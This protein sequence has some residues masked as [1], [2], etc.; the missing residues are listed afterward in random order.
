MKSL[1]QALRLLTL[2]P[3]PGRQF[4]ASGSLESGGTAAAYPLAGLVIGILSAAA[5]WCA[6]MILGVW[7]IA[8]MATVARI[9]ITGGMHLDGLADLADGWGGGR[10]RDKR[11]AIMAD[12]RLGSF[13]ALALMVVLCL[14]TVFI[15]EWINSAILSQNSEV[16]TFLP[17]VLIPALSR[18]MIPLLM[19]GFPA[20]RPGGMGKQAR[21][22]VTFIGAG[23]ALLF[24]VL[25]VSACFFPSG[26]I[27]SVS[28][29]MI[30]S[31]A[32]LGISK[33][34]GGLTGD[35][36]GALIEIG[37]TAGFLGVLIFLR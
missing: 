18:G 27:L 34:L 2:L 36:Y 1:I 5:A 4:G 24:G 7:G 26:L 22:S 3:I 21:S 19:K 28:V 13:G 9:I 17:V 23:M 8:V 20:A 12:S 30:M 35:C 31:V 33:S 16:M 10:D 6:G 32:G 11:L 29:F 14:Q 15:F 37:D 25:P